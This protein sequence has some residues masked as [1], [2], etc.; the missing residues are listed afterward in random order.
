MQC[1]TDN[2]NNFHF[3]QLHVCYMI[4]LYNP[5]NLLSILLVDLAAPL[6]LLLFYLSKKSLLAP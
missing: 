6:Y 2:S 5:V 4:Q 3:P 1:V